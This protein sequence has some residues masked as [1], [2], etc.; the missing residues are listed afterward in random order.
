MSYNNP[1]ETTP[2]QGMRFFVDQY[3][4]PTHTTS[5]THAYKAP[6]F[7]PGFPIGSVLAQGYSGGKGFDGETGCS[8]GGGGGGAGGEGGYRNHCTTGD[9]P[10]GGIG[11]THAILT[12]ISHGEEDSGAYYIGGGG[13]G[14]NNTGA[15][16]EGGLGGG[17]NGL[18]T[19]PAM[20]VEDGLVNTGGGGGGGH[21]GNGGAGGHGVIILKIAAADYDAGAFQTDTGSLPTRTTSAEISGYRYIKITGDGTLQ[22]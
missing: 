10:D 18:G 11:I 13:G 14:V 8:V 19:S 17:G 21:S 3:Y 5:G 9:D 22:G 4:R 2:G 12:A 20:A 6:L 1:P 16:G 15:G 7:Y